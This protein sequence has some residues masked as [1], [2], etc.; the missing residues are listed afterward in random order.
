MTDTFNFYYKRAYT[1]SVKFNTIVD[2][3]FSAKEQRRDVWTNP[4]RK[5]ILEFE[6]NKLD[7]EALVNFFI[8]QKGRK[9]AFNWTWAVDK[10]GDDV[11]YLVRFDTD[12]LQ[13]DVLEMGYSTF[14]LPII[15]VFE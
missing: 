12:E 2:E 5:W 13:L 15:Q 7:R 9:K 8:A 11:T 6:K 14:S 1:A 4:R 10:G 3:T